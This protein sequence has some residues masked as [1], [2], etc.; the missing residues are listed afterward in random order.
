LKPA[1]PP[2]EFVKTDL[3]YKDERRANI[4]AAVVD[5]LAT[6]S[7]T[8]STES[9]LTK[10]ESWAKTAHPTDHVALHI[11]GFGLAGFQY[12]RMLFGAEASRSAAPAISAAI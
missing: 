7:G 10:F 8:G 9:Q 1:H 2:H 5:W 3:N 12:L 6:I 4:L 11:R